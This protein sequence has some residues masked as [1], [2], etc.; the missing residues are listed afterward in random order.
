MNFE[1]VRKETISERLATLAGAIG[2]LEA[3]IDATDNALRATSA[4]ELSAAI[5]AQSKAATRTLALKQ[6]LQQSLPPSAKGK[7]QL[8]MQDRLRAHPQAAELLPQFEQIERRLQAGQ[9]N[10]KQQ[11]QVV[12]KMQ[13]IN[14][15]LLGVLTDVDNHGYNRQ[16]GRSESGDGR[17]IAKA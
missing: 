9:M 2:A 10:L 3:A 8:S 14:R 12:I 1:A 16:G 15:Q 7:G 11:A 6:H 17:V 5:T 4:D 13:A